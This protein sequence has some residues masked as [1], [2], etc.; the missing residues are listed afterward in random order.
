[1]EVKTW[2][3]V[4][5][6]ECGHED[7]GVGCLLLG[8]DLSAEEFRESALGW[9]HTASLQEVQQLGR[10]QIVLGA[11]SERW[12]KGWRGKAAGVYLGA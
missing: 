4:E 12:S 2:T 6:L 10:G 3:N 11:W 8:D 1:M 5:R 7:V 9:G